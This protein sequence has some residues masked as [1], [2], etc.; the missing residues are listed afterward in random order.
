VHLEQNDIEYF[1]K[2][3]AENHKFWTRL[4]G[5]PSFKGKTILDVGC[6]HGALCVDMAS[7]G[8]KKVVGIDI[9]NHR[10]NFANSNII[11]NYPELQSIIEFKCCDIF[12]LPK[13]K[14]D[15]IVSE[16]AFEH[17]IKPDKCLCEMKVRLK[18]NGKIYIGF[19]PLYNSPYGDHKRTEA[20]IPWGHLIFPEERLIKKL[21]KKYRERNIECIEDLGLNKM[22]FKEWK[23]LFNNSGLR[24]VY[25]KVNCSKNLIMRIFS[26]LRRVSYLEEYFSYNLYCILEKR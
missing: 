5:N 1:N 8:A 25:F 20:I 2:S 13:Y 3:F 17:I 19:S 9:S 4:K 14:F 7:Q 6:G 22:S 16:D 26:L 15:I 18:V 24:L 21:K 10:I 12:T 23:K 11:Q